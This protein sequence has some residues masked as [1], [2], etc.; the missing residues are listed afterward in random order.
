MSENFVNIKPFGLNVFTGKEA[1]GNNKKTKHFFEEENNA[2]SQVER[3]FTGEVAHE[4]DK[5]NMQTM[6]LGIIMR[7]G[8]ETHSLDLKG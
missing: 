8:L 5:I 3:V 2:P 1:Q 6:G 4:I 7:D